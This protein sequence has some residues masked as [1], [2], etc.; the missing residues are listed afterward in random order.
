MSESGVSATPKAKNKVIGKGKNVQPKAS[1]SQIPDSI[2]DV[3]DSDSDLEAI[4]PPSESQGTFSDQTT[5]KSTHKRLTPAAKRKASDDK[6][7]NVMTKAFEIKLENKPKSTPK[8]QD[9][10]SAFIES[11][12]CALRSLPDRRSVLV[13][14]N[15]IQ[16][17]MFSCEMELLPPKP[18]TDPDL[19]IL[20]PI[21]S[22]QPS[23]QV[24]PEPKFSYP[25]PRAPAKHSDSKDSGSNPKTPCATQCDSGSHETT[26]CL[27]LTPSTV[28]NS[29]PKRVR[30]LRIK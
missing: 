16:N 6:L 10:I 7:V 4:N 13:M 18:A 24:E 27:D 29:R 17:A 25:G 3:V 2:I 22:A 20:T 14:K 21:S 1:T 5:T 30:K 11:I 12:G 26:E 19:E 9:E 15:A 28:T 23:P 8:P